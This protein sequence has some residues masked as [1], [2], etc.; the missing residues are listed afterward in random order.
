[1]SDKYMAGKNK[2]NVKNRQS[3]KIFFGLLAVFL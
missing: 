3:L 1:M 2:K